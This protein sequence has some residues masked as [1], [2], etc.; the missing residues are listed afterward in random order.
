MELEK[1]SI[2]PLTVFDQA[3]IHPPCKEYVLAILL[4]KAESP[5]MRLNDNYLGEGG[6][7]GLHLLVLG[8]KPGDLATFASGLGP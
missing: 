4:G 3:G 6:I 7:P 5:V 8:T 2:C 1:L